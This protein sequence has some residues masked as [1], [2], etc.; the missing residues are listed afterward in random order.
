M[1]CPSPRSGKLLAFI[2]GLTVA[3]SV[4]ATVYT[5]ATGDNYGPSYVDIANVAVTN[6]ATDLT[7]Q[8]NLNPSAN[9]NHVDGNG[10]FDQFYGKYQIGI[11]TGPGGNPAIVNNFGN[12]VGIST[13]VNYSLLGWADNIAAP[14]AP[15]GSPQGYDTT[16]HW[17]G[18]GWDDVAGFASSPFVDTPTVITDTS[19]S[20]TIPL[21]ALGLSAGNTFK[22]DV[23]TTFSGGGQSAYDALDKAT[24]TTDPGTPYGTATP[25]DSATSPGSTLSSYTI[26]SVITGPLW[27]GAGNGHWSES[28]N[29]NGGIPNAI[30]QTANFGSL[31]S[32]NYAVALDDAGKTVGTINFDSAT[33]YT[34]GTIGGNALTMQVSAGSAGINVISGNHTI[35][36]PIM[37]ASDT[38]ITTGSASTLSV[39][40]PLVAAGRTIAK[41]GA[42]TLQLTRVQADLL[43]I[44]GGTV[45]I[46]AQ[47]LQQRRGHE[48]AQH[49][50]CLGRRKSICKTMR[51]ST[52][53]RRSAHSPT[54]SVR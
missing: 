15:G 41:A 19:V 53:T 5:D 8:I 26:A 38:A 47:A 17:N 30:D 20:Y 39:T 14:T 21:A 35:A 46:A 28:G 16:Y 48:R 27:T 1:R 54:P 11:Q 43:N 37:L 49:V 51:W 7:F 25:Y 31:T 9:L 42:G 33:S 44:T 3:E 36:A 4:R 23:W 40:S 6:T 29:W 10:N 34:I 32:G 18:T 13:G 52:I 12:Q 45:T 50:V 24:L 22:F 2:A